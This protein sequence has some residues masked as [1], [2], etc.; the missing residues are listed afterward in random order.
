MRPGEQ[1]TTDGVVEWGESTADES[2]LN[3]ESLPRELRPGVQVLAGTTN[4]A[5]AVTVRVTATGNQ[6]LAG[7]MARD[8]DAML[9]CRPRVLRWLDKFSQWYVPAVGISAAAVWAGTGSA[10]RAAALLVS[11][12]PCA[13]ALAGPAAVLAAISAAWRRGIV[14]RPDG[15][16]ESLAD[17]RSVVLDKTGTITCGHL[18][19][20]AWRQLDSQRSTS[21]ILAIARR[22]AS[23]SVHPIALAIMQFIQSRDASPCQAS[24]DKVYESTGEGVAAVDGGR[25]IRLGKMDW[26]KAAGVDCHAAD[27][28]DVAAHEGPATVLAID[29]Q[30]VACFLLADAVRE[31]SRTSLDRLRALGVSRLVMFTGDRAAAARAAAAVLPLDEVRADCSPQNKC[32]AVRRERERF[33]SVAMVGDGANDAL[34]MAAS[35]VGIAIDR[36]EL[37]VAQGTADVVL[38]RGGLEGLPEALQL[39]RRSRRLLIVNLTLA[40]TSTAALATLAALGQLSTMTAAVVHNAGAALVLIHSGL[41]VL[42][43][44]YRRGNQRM[45]L[46]CVGVTDRFHH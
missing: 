20:V 2:L 24:L 43:D 26:L 21:D 33:G 6:T 11:C 27:L 7:R 15:R 12:C 38:M 42:R 8:F 31:T 34:A 28:G 37:P 40:A 1:F 46:D 17:V 35:N 36:A 18:S 32:D 10:S 25:W 19:V 9:A 30:C 41:F 4:G 44:A 13:L 45:V 23:C 29:Q 39:A 22:V 16:W 14:F 3:G 5:G